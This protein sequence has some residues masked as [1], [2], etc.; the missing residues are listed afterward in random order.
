MVI[1]PLTRETEATQHAIDLPS[2]NMIQVTPTIDGGYAFI[3]A[4]FTGSTESSDPL[5]L[6]P[7]AGIYGVF[8]G[9][10]ELPVRDPSVLYQ[11]TSPIS[12]IA[13]SLIRGSDKLV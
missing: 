8:L 1:I 2:Q 3:F 10:G 12:F 6:S 9:Y 4:N 13:A 11:T 7:R 5:S